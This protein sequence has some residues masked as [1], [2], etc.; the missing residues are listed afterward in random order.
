M[1]T[2]HSVSVT[3]KELRRIW[4]KHIEDRIHICILLLDFYFHTEGI[5][6]VWCLLLKGAYI[7]KSGN[8]FQ[9]TTYNNAYLGKTNIKPSHVSTC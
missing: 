7:D 4:G 9:S 2:D 3:Y 8:Y 1:N 5:N 6:K